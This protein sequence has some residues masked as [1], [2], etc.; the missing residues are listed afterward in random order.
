MGLLIYALSSFLQKKDTVTES[1]SL[2][3]IACLAAEDR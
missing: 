3:D 1:S 2:W